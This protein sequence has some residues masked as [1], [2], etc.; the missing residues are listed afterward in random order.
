FLAGTGIGI[1]PIARVDHRPIGSGRTGEI[2]GSVRRLYFDAARGKLPA[3]RS[4]CRPVGKSI[5][6][7]EV[8]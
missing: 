6:R 7:V 8:A 1:I 4:W 2:T 5:Q 3:Y